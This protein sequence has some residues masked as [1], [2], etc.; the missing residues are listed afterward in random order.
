MFPQNEKKSNICIYHY[1]IRDKKSFL[2]KMINGGKQLEQNH[3][4]HIGM[5]WRYFYE[6][7]KNGQLEKEYDRITGANS[8]EQLRHDGFIRTDNTIAEFFKQKFNK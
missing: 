8:Y 7:Y 5:H 6:L 3:H 1:S 2:E 4:K